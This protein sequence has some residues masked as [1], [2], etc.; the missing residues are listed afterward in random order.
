[1]GRELGR[2]TGAVLAVAMLVAPA[3]AAEPQLTQASMAADVTV[4]RTAGKPVKGKIVACTPEL[5]TVAPPAKG[6]AA[7][8]DPVDLPWTDVR[9]V[10]NGLTARRALDVWKAGHKDQLCADCRGE[11][12]VA[13][14]TCHGTR[15]DPA[16]AASCKTCHGELLVACKSAGEVDGRVGCPNGCL[17]R[18]VGTWTKGAEGKTWHRFT[19][20]GGA[21]QAYSEG[22]V[23]DV[24]V[25][26][27]RARTAVD[28]GPCPECGKAG[29]VDDPVCHGTGKVAC[30]ECLA[31]KAAPPC[32]DHCDGGRVACPTCHASGLKAAA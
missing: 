11:R 4:A 25:V 19:F 18:D 10:S 29:R 14:P 7:A 26:D 8:A 15:H 9:A 23:G 3:W 6:D 13:C 12:T 21:W 1:M 32:P 24:I 17:R 30:R 20:P 5:L 27:N 22:H 16:A 2:V 28:A 31:R